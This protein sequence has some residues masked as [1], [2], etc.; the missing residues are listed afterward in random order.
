MRWLSERGRSR[1][2]D[3]LR[4]PDSVA[5]SIVP[6]ILPPQTAYPGAPRDKPGVTDNER[7]HEP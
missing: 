3:T 5:G 4:L 6:S 1:R 7:N 2:L